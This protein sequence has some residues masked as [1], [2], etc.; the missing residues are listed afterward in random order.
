MKQNII[1]EFSKITNTDMKDRP[2]LKKKKKKKKKKKERKKTNADKI[3]KLW[4]K[5]YTDRF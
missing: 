1:R 5:R 4:N 3:G 2:H